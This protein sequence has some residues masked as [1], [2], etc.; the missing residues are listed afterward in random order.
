MS[1]YAIARIRSANNAHPELVEYLQK[2][3]ATLDPYSGR[4]LVHGGGRVDEVEGSWDGIGVIAI[5]FPD[6]ASVD[7]WYH[8]DAYQKIAPLRTRNTE[9]DL[10]LVDGVS[11][12]H[13][14]ASVLRPS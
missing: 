4:F 2:I 6:R 7:E 11:D 8:S 1:A 14:P 5:G 12:T 10:I 13:D 3:Q 9:M